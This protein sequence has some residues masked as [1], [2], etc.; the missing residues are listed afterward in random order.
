[1]KLKELI[2]AIHQCNIDFQTDIARRV[3]GGIKKEN[4]LL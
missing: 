2:T 3:K 4:L 1:M